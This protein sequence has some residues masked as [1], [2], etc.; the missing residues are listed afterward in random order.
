MIQRLTME[1]KYLNINFKED[2]RFYYANQCFNNE[3]GINQ[4]ILVVYTGWVEIN[5]LF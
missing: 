3:I 1:N 5:S 4:Q 2:I